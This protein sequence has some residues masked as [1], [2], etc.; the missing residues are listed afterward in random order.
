MTPIRRQYLNLKHS[1]PDAILLFRLGDFYEA[2]D[3]DARLAA[4]ELEITLTARSMGKDTKVPMAGVPAHAL[5]SYLARLIRKGHKVAICEQLSDPATSR[6]LVARDVVRVVTPGTVLEP[7]LLEQKANNYLAAVV[8]AA[9]PDGTLGAGL[10]YVDITTGEFAVTQLEGDRLALE[11]ERIAPAEVLV[12]RSQEAPQWAGHGPATNGQQAGF[13][14][15]PVDDADF[16]LNAA[17]QALLD[18]Y[19]VLSLEGFGCA[20]LPLAVRAAGAIV[21]YLGRTQRAGR[22]QLAAL[23]TYSTASYMTLDAQTRRNLELFQA[24]RAEGRQL[25]LLATLDLTGTPMGA[26]LLRRWLGQ[27]LLDLAALERRLDAV[28]CFFDDAFRRTEA[29][30]LLGQVPDLERILARIQAGTVTP[31]ELLALQAG[32]TAAGR[33]AERLSDDAGPLAWLCRELAP[34]PQVAG[35]IEQAIAPEPGGPVGEGTVIREGFSPELDALKTASRDARRFIAGLETRERERTGIKSLKVGYNQVFGYYIEVSK[36]N[37]GQVPPDYIRRQTLTGGE[38]YIVA[39]LKEYESLVL[40][41]RERVDELERSLYRQVCAQMGQSAPALSR[42]AG[43]VAQADVFAAL[44]EVA[45][46]HGYVRPRL[47]L[48]STIAIKNGRHPVVERVLPPGSYVPNDVCLSNDDA[49]LIVLTGPNMAGKSTFIRQAAIIT[50]MAQVG[51]FVPASEAAIGLVDRIFTRVGLQ[52]DLTTGQSTFM[53]EMVE[54]AAILNQATPRSLVILDEIGRGTS[55]YDGLSIARAVIEHLHN[56]PRLGCK[57]LFA[58]HYHELTEAAATLPGVR[59]FSVAVAEEEG[60][61]VFL[62]RIVPGGADRSYGVHVAQLAGLPRAVVNR[63]WE[64]L[65]ELEQ[66]PQAAGITGGT[67]GRRR[68]AGAAAAQLTLF[69]AAPGGE[70]LLEAVLALDVAN[71]TPLEAIN[72]LYQLQEQARQRDGTT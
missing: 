66:R 51:S 58:T 70:R 41:A 72:K 11:L 2:F 36:A 38:R 31:R 18:Y 32:L 64:V 46:R 63:A 45:V 54:T 10:A 42:L 52:D 44:A 59:N 9:L 49:R 12:P 24:G 27:P 53:V 13:P 35:L 15:T 33:L 30:S 17:R 40:N 47:D 1:Y 50:L 69:S 26:R 7:A 34:V 62:H 21:A 37:L 48:S 68:R 60:R 56:H 55:T 3:D 19:Q 67:G 6:G 14:V 4:R 57:T 22:A 43:A 25:S 61:V 28:G 23:N 8:E 39:E 65:A 5:E 29:R 71:L 16:A 20:G